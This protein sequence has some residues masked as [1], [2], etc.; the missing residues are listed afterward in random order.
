MSAIDTILHGDAL[1]TLRTLDS[2]SVNCIVTSP[3]Y[4]GLRDYGVAGQIGL[5]PTP[6]AYVAALVSVLREARRV[7]RTDGTCW[8]NLGDS[9]AGSGRGGQSEEKRSAH[10]QPTYANHGLTPAGLKPKDLCMIPARVALALQSDGWWLRSEIVW[11]KPSPMPESVTDR[12]TRAHEMIYLLAKSARYYYDADAISEPV[13]TGSRGSLFTIGKTAGRVAGGLLSPVG[14][15]PRTETTRR[16][17][18]DVWTVATHPFPEAHFATFPPALIEPCVLAGC[19]A[20]GVVLDPFMGAGTVGVVAR[21]HSRH[22]LGIEL[23]P[24]YIMM[25]ETR[26]ANERQPVLWSIASSQEVTA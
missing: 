7:L 23:N 12:P 17:K 4:F 22:Y 24:A 9:Y 6:E 16:N 10:W 26:I 3:P 13:A 11:A 19:P 25:A 2:G 21:R 15:G 8:I 14:Q 18:R 1:T 5:E 20:G